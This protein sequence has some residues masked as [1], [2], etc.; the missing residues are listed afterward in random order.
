METVRAILMSSSLE[1][2]SILAGYNSNKEK[3]N[4]SD[5]L[6]TRYVFVNHLISNILVVGRN[7]FYAKLEYSDILQSLAKNLE[8]EIDDKNYVRNDF[9]ELG[10]AKR[11]MMK[12]LEHIPTGQKSELMQILGFDNKKCGVSNKDIMRCLADDL[13]DFM[14]YRLLCWLANANLQ[15]FLGNA[16][17]WD[18]KSGIAFFGKNQFRE[19]VI[20]PIIHI[21]ML[22]HQ[23]RYNQ[24]PKCGKCATA[25]IPGS[26]FCNECGAKLS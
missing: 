11:Y 23:Y 21:T 2:L 12:Y 26:K 4:Y 13:P 18:S 16:E 17:T 7:F 8:V 1:E 19:Q 24:V 9:I 3:T 15:S 25:I 5:D 6:T 22:R 10:I 20:Y 14:N